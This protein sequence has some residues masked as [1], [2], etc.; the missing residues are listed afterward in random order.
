MIRII[1][2]QSKI[3]LKLIEDFTVISILII[4]AYQ[5]IVVIRQSSDFHISDNWNSRISL[6]IRI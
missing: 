2:K 6:Y 3:Q 1:K 5:Y 4:N